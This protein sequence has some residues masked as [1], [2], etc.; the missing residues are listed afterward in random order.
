MG[1]QVNFYMLPKDEAEFMEALRAR[2]EFIIIGSPSMTQTPTILD[3]LPVEDSPVVWRDTVYLGRP[4]CALFTRRVTMQAGPLQ[5]KALYF[6][7]G[8]D[9]SVVEFGR[10][11]L[12][13]DGV[14]TRGRIWAEMRRLEGKHFVYK[15][16]EFEEWYDSMAAWIRRHYRKVGE[17]PYFYI[18]P[19]AYKWWQA[20]GQL[21][22]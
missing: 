4:G 18:G 17:R 22:P 10:C 12:R 3:E 20:G 11:V 7:D 19:E 14:L 6:I 13:D 21:Q 15:G 9:S 16:R 8:S 5:G 2:T 1:K